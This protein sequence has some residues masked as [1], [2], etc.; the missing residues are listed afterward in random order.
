MYNTT[1]HRAS[2]TRRGLPPQ[3]CAASHPRFVQHR[4]TS[5]SYQPT[6]RK[7]SF[8]TPDGTSAQYV[9]DHPNGATQDRPNGAAWKYPNRG[10]ERG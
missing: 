3:P 6:G 8:T 5:A 9:T 10:L 7:A 1:T 4:H 2:N